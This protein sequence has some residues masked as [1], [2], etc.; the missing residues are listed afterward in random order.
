MVSDTTLLQER[1]ALSL[2]NPSMVPLPEEWRQSP[3]ERCAMLRCHGMWL[4]NARKIGDKHHLVHHLVHILVPPS[5]HS[6]ESFQK[7]NL[8]VFKNQFN[9]FSHFS[10]FFPDLPMKP[11]RVGNQVVGVLSTHGVVRDLRPPVLL[12]P[13][14]PPGSSGPPALPFFGSL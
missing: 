1:V 2:F 6:F 11:G 7:P 3:E 14:E 4:K 12:Y 9:W 10:W 8:L 13:C 5:F